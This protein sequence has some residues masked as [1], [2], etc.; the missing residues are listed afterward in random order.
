MRLTSPHGISKLD[1]LMRLSNQPVAFR[2]GRYA[3][4]TGW[5]RNLRL[6]DAF[7]DLPRHLFALPAS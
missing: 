7:I 5:R 1:L 4:T 3:A 6:V 2:T